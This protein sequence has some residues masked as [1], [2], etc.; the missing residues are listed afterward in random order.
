M[1]ENILKYFYLLLIFNINGSIAK[2]EELIRVSLD[3]V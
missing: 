2:K 1:F 3:L